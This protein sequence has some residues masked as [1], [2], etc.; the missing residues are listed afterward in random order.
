MELVKILLMVVLGT[1]LGISCVVLAKIRNK[2]YNVFIIIFLLALVSWQ[3]C[4]SILENS[5]YM[6]HHFLLF[7]PYYL[8]IAFG[9][10]LYLYKVYLFDESKKI[11]ATVIHMTPIIIQVGFQVY[12]WLKP[13]NERLAYLR[14]SFYSYS[15]DLIVQQFLSFFVSSIYLF[16][17]WRSFISRKNQLINLVRT[18]SKQILLYSG[19][20]LKYAGLIH[21]IW[22]VYLSVAIFSKA[23]PNQIEPLLSIPMT[24]FILSLVYSI[25]ENPVLLTGVI[26]IKRSSLVNFPLE[27]KMEKLGI[28]LLLDQQEKKN[29]YT[30]EQMANLLMVDES[31]LSNYLQLHYGY[32]NNTRVF[33]GEVAKRDT[34]DQHV[35][36]I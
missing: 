21:L 14:E 12:W 32:K 27:R 5:T 30:L 9:P 10:S 17:A 19:K 18:E 22:A 23:S 1:A 8:P 26:V 31:Y 35:E 13:Y 4:V 6:K 29:L 24:L 25:I 34:H 15:G 20:L 11:R 36:I 28:N 16:F 2:P 33:K 7:L 3:A